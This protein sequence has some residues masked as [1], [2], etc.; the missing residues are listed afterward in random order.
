MV[1]DRL[2]EVSTATQSQTADVTAG[3]VLGA[4]L[5][6]DRAGGG[7]RP[8]AE[9]IPRVGATGRASCKNLSFKGRLGDQQPPFFYFGTLFMSPK[10]IELE[11]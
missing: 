3:H 4:L 9:S 2:T 8:A 6:Y 11:S 1:N 7:A 5:A 10:L